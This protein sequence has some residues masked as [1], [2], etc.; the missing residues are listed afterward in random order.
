MPGRLRGGRFVNFARMGPWF[1]RRFGKRRR[2][3][4]D[5]S[6]GGYPV[7]YFLCPHAPQVRLGCAW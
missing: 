4:V 3:T 2:G 6:G 5:F 1:E 7:R